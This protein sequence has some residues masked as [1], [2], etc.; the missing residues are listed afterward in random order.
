MPFR[1]LP[2]TDV[3]LQLAMSKLISAYDLRVTNQPDE[4]KR[5]YA[6]SPETYAELKDIQLLFNKEIDERT[7]ALSVR[8][9]S[10][11]LRKQVMKKLKKCVDHFF[12]VLNLAIDREVLKSTVR[13]LYGLDVN[14]KDIPVI[15]SHNDLVNWANKIIHGETYRIAAGEI[16]VQFPSLA[17]VQAAYDDYIAKHQNL[18]TVAINL[19]TQQTDVKRLRKRIKAAIRDAWDQ[20]EFY[21]RRNTPSGKRQYA[22]GWGIE[23]SR[24]KGEQ[25]EKG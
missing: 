21:Y 14:Q 12:I 23:Y 17:D 13:P 11:L 2:L 24:K 1:K 3:Q 6:F 8:S 19:I 20:I 22:R 9:T 4:T 10:V 7:D 18:S 15:Y 25:P 5:E 16:P